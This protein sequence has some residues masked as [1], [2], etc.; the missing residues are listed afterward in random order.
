MYKPVEKVHY[1]EMITLEACD[2]IRNQ[3][4]KNQPYFLHVSY[5]SPQVN[6]ITKKPQPPQKW[7]STFEGI[8]NNSDQVGHAGI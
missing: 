4:K 2:I 3:T 1:T 7:I 5:Q 6:S 8:F